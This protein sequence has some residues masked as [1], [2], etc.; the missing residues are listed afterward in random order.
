[1]ARMIPDVAPAM[2]SP[3][4][5][6]LFVRF[7]DE[8]GTG[9][10]TVLHSFDLSEHVARVSGE[11]DFVVIVPGRGVLVLEVKAVQSIRRENGVW[12]L[13]KAEQGDPRGPFKQAADAMHSLREAVSHRDP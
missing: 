2:Q 8:P 1:M 13:G 3:G 10:W 12:F 4:E 6:E 7:R 5:A 11:V 9:D